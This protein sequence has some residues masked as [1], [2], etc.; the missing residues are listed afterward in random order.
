[1]T[2]DSTVK[3]IN[4][5]GFVEMLAGGELAALIIFSVGVFLM[6][7][8]VIGWLAGPAL[9][10]VAVLVGIAHVVGIFEKKPG[11]AGH[12]PYCG[13]DAIA[14]D[15]GSVSKCDECKN[16]FVHREGRLWKVEET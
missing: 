3:R 13:A 15:P 9:M 16:R 2:I 12:C 5:P 8:P 6:V 4:P 14:G 7:V 1:M 10:I 11:Y